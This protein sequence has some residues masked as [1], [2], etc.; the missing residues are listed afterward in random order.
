MKICLVLCIVFL[1]VIAVSSKKQS[2]KYLKKVYKECQKNN[3]TRVDNQILKKIKKN[4][5]VTLPDNYGAHSLCILKGLGYINE[6]ATINTEK[7]K[8][9]VAKKVE[10]DEVEDIAFECVAVTDT[11]EETALHLEKCLRSHKIEPFQPVQSPHK[12]CYN[13]IAL[14][15]L[16]AAVVVVTMVS[17]EKQVNE[18]LTPYKRTI[19]ECQ[20]NEAT[21]IDNKLLK[22]IKKNEDVE[23]P[24]NYGAH[25]L[26]V[27][28]G[29]RYMN[30][31]NTINEEKL[32]RNVA[33][34]VTDDSEE[35]EEI[36]KKCRVSKETPEMTALHIKSCLLSYEIDI[37]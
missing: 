22:K 29:L 11:P 8:K 26:C 37:I 13:Q 36:L 21:K 30:E 1:A 16:S 3:E 2:G 34:K 6:D 10:E 9:K 27:M 12:S 14:T 5:Q 35:M 15:V 4:M 18:E 7:L 25:V 28:K 19:R 23:L 31:N 17:A 32:A 33:K 24:A 20:R